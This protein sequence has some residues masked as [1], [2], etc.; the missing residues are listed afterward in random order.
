MRS[1]RAKASGPVMTYAAELLAQRI[2]GKSLEDAGAELRITGQ[3]LGRLLNGS[4]RPCLDLGALIE[5][6]FAIPMILWTV[7]PHGVNLAGST[8]ASTD[9]PAALRVAR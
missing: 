9:T 8:S 7:K 6:R 5:K 2:A 3:H 4:R 1:P